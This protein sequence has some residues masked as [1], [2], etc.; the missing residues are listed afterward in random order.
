MAEDNSVIRRPLGHTSPDWVR[1]VGEMMAGGVTASWHGHM[2]V[3][4]V[5]GNSQEFYH[6]ITYKCFDIQWGSMQRH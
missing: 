2:V 5:G 3:T 1:R 6:L 4:G